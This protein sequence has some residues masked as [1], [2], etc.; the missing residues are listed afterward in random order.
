LDPLEIEECA[1]GDG[2]TRNPCRIFRPLLIS[3]GALCGSAY[4]DMGF[5]KFV[6]F[7]VGE[8]EYGKISEKHRKRMM[9]DFDVQVKRS[10]GAQE[11]KNR[12]V[13]LRGVENND[14]EGIIDENI[15]LSA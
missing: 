8:A 2:K 4:I 15:L 9:L 12:T 3:I 13:E 1:M 14:R 10:F 5:E 6:K 7:K 11:Q